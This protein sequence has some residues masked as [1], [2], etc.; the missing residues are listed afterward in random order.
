MLKRI[1]ILSVAV[2]LV[3]VIS[4]PTQAQSGYA[5]TLRAGTLGAELGLVRTISP[6]MNARV[7][8]NYFSL[9][10][11]GKTESDDPV[12]YDVDLNLFAISA[13]VDYHPFANWFR[14]SGGLVY[15]NSY[16]EGTG[17]A[18]KSYSVSGK[19]YTPDEIGTLTA[20]AEPSLLMTPYIG[21]GIGNPISDGKKLS[22]I[23]DI[24]MLY[25]GSPEVTL[26]ADESAMIYPTT[27]Q[28]AD[29]EEDIKNLK[30]YPFIGIGISYQF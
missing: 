8:F 29:V 26:D 23:M 25:F 11:S 28:E 30:F 10:Q 19:V 1:T 20:K 3:L 18:V 13:L 6:K 9:N 15:N 16:V 22:F 21:I 5:V 27:K 17:K 7:G 12:K 14:L 24:G 4:V 2:L